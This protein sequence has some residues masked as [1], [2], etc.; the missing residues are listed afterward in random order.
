MF[1]TVLVLACFTERVREGGSDGAKER[2]MS[3]G[4]T[5][6]SGVLRVRERASQQC[7]KNVTKCSEFY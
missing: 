5:Q 7:S 3:E 2:G 4:V 1:F 6:R